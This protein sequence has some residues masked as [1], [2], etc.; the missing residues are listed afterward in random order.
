MKRLKFVKTSGLPVSESSNLINIGVD[1]NGIL[2]TLDNQGNRP[3]VGS[4]VASN[5]Q[6]VSYTLQFSD[7]G[8]I[9]E[10]NVGA[11]NS[12]TIPANSS[13]PFL[14]GTQIILTQYGSGQTG[15]TY[16]SPVTVRSSSNRLKLVSQYSAAT[17][18]KIGTDEWYL[19]GDIT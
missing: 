13:V 19:F 4:L 18:V 9:V 7:A 16:S 10:M 11:T 8:K 3:S 1:Q 12:I 15:V 14:N 5:R 2:T 6:T 17:L